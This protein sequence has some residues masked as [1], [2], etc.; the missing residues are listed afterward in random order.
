MVDVSGKSETVR[1]A[2]AEATVRMRPAT[3]RAIQR[4]N[5]PKGDVLGVAR[6]ARH[7]RA[8]SERPS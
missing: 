2:I 1:E 7:P 8:P 5:A 6:T 3:L 4:G